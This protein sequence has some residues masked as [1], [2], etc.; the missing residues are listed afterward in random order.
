MHLTPSKE[1]FAAI[2]AL[3]PTEATN[4]KAIAAIHLFFTIISPQNKS[5]RASP[6]HNT[7]PTDYSE[8]ILVNETSR[9][10]GL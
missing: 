8:H 5:I 2:A 10:V 7:V 3:A 4:V 6:I 1:N 9:F